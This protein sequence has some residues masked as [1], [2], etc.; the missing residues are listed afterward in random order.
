[1]LKSDISAGKK[2]LAEG[3]DLARTDPT[4]A[5][6]R[7]Q[8]AF[9]T[10]LPGMRKV[11]FKHEV[12]RDVTPREDLRTVLLKEIDEEKTPEKFRG[13]ELRMKALGLIPRD[14]DLKLT[15]VKVYSEEIA[16]FYDTKT[17]TMHLIKELPAV[18]N[19][20]PSLFERLLGKKGGF[21]PDE[22]KT[23]I[24]HE[25]THALAD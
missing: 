24:A 4:E 13:D 25:L 16:A 3:D 22:N 21:D 8:K 15:M 11:R 14:L 18:A 1:D 5:V 20:K 9:E 7:Y 2:L 19:K 17:E 23:V 6:I 10:L 12:K